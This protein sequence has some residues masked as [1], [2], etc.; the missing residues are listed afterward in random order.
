LT[1]SENKF[2]EATNDT[3]PF[4]HLT[5]RPVDHPDRVVILDAAPP[6]VSAEV[7]DAAQ[8]QLKANK[9][10]AR[11][12]QRYEELYLLRGGYA[13][14]GYCG[15]VMTAISQTV[16]GKP[17]ARKFNYR[18][19]GVVV[20]PGMTIC[21][22]GYFA[23]AASVID[24]AVWDTITFLFEDPKRIHTL[25]SYQASHVGKQSDWTL[26]RMRA[27][28]GLLERV[29][30]QKENAARAVLDAE[31]PETFALWN[32]KV[33]ELAVQER[34]LRNELAQLE[35]SHRKQKLA[36]EHLRSIE[37]WVSALGS[38]LQE[39]TYAE[40][41][42]FLRAL[43]VKVTVYRSDHTPRYV[44]HF[45]LSRLRKPLP[46]LDLPTL[47][48][49]DVQW[50]RSDRPQQQGASPWRQALLALSTRS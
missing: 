30:R 39:T 15:R 40:R 14:C 6:I 9:R 16:K 13:V 41:R 19:N 37:Q 5:L 32:S 7:W 23:I 21:E 31:S 29:E 3:R 17:D 50:L 25:L 18:C 33:E 10:Q 49:S 43:D 38:T 27:T 44:I 26:E 48:D 1:T 8:E 42:Q 22:G 46:D 11:R 24:S 34:D 12:N 2:D 36:A 20:I 4:Y 47:T 28:T 35:A 45:D